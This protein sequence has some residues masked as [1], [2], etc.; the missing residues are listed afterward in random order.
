MTGIVTR[1]R[2]TISLLLAAAIALLGPAADQAAEAGT[3]GDVRSLINAERVESGKR[4]LR[5]SGKLSRIARRHSIRMARQNYLHHNGRLGYQARKMS[6]T[7]LGENVGV[8]T[9]VSSLHRAFMNSAPH[10]ANVMK[11]RYRRVGVGTVQ[12]GGRLWV[13][14][15]FAN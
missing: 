6:W 4:A 11:G 12:S 13:T 5:R 7:V 8:G 9:S 14:V 2:G 15:V 3:A 1:R 10:R